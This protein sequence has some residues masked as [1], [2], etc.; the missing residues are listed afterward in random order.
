MPVRRHTFVVQVREPDRVPMLE[1][2]RTHERVLLED[3][4]GVSAQIRAW[5]AE[6]A[7]FVAGLTATED[8]VLGAPPGEAGNG[9]LVLLPT[10]HPDAELPR[11]PTLATPEGDEPE[12]QLRRFSSPNGA[13]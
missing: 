10:P 13:D 12:P 2:V 5:L 6:D 3:L 4:A 1:N 11:H 8:A 9:R 7:A